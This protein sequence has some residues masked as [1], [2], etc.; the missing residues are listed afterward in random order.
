[1]IWSDSIC[2][3][4]CGCDKRVLARGLCRGH[5][6]QHLKG[7]PLTALRVY[8]CAKPRSL[9]NCSFDGC[10][11]FVTARD[12]CSGH[13]WQ[14]HKGHPLAP[15][16]VGRYLDRNCTSPGCDREVQGRGLCNFHY[17]KAYTTRNV[18]KTRE[19]HLKTKFGMCLANYNMLLLRQGG[20]CAICSQKCISGRGLAVDHD[21]DSGVIRGLLCT[22]CN[23]ALGLMQEDTDN[24]MNS[25]KYLSY[26]QYSISQNSP[27]SAND[28][29]TE[30]IENKA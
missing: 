1:M 25:V 8:V 13:Y 10:T 24:L 22:R 12:L 17:R 23:T 9:R 11:K 7:K 27:K 20:V 18:E 19:H 15:L 30:A 28:N 16:R 29:A 21:H 6:N 2:S 14:Q 5:Y 4:E 26:R 3:A